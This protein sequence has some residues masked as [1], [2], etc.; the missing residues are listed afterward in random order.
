M[1][2]KILGT[3]GEIEESAPYHSKYSGI[4]VDG[5]FLFDL[6]EKEYLKYNP[7]AIILTHFHPDH[8][9][10]VRWSKEEN[11]PTS[12]KIFAPEKLK[13]A[14]I[15]TKIHV[16]S[17]KF[18]IEDYTIVPIPT[19]HSKNVK[20]Q[21]YLVKKEG[22]SFLYTGDLI[23][24][25]K[26]YYALFDHVDLII[27]EG[28]FLRKGGMVRKDQVT[29]KLYGHNGIPNLIELF[30]PYTKKI[31]F[32]HFGVWFYENIKISCKKIRALGKENEIE[33]LVGYDGQEIIL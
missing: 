27:T 33:A 11:P 15:T 2:L 22:K 9:Y 29:Q 7:E 19:H 18:K 4:L 14:K 30:K 1:K 17:K 10:F 21:A 24:I 20:S 3:K 8:A 6:G 26:Q 28:S 25:D 31:L 23:W 12:A 32:V 13:N 16:I 5:R